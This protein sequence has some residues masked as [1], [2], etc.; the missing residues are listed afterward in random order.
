[1]HLHKAKMDL[2]EYDSLKWIQPNSMHQLWSNS[3]KDAE[4]GSNWNW[5]LKQVEIFISG[6]ANVP[7]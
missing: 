1:M 2:E 4:L 3:V 5:N 7:E 6:M